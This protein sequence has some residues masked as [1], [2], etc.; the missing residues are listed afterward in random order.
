VKGI[1]KIIRSQGQTQFLS[2]GNASTRPP[3]SRRSWERVL[4]CK[5]IYSASTH[6]NGSIELQSHQVAWVDTPA[7]LAE[8]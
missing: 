4:A 7:M 2:H 1:L 5:L 3:G 6:S 8:R